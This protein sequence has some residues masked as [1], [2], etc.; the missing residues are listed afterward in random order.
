M[1]VKMRTPVAS[2][3]MNAVR[4]AVAGLWL[5]RTLSSTSYPFPLPLLCSPLSRWTA[6][7]SSSVEEGTK[8]ARAQ[9]RSEDLDPQRFAR[10]RRCTASAA[11]K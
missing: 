11:P 10:F 6:G 8:R 7:L 1:L 9:A 3:G 2:L 5:R 4:H